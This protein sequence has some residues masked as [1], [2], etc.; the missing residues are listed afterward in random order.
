MGNPQR[1]A[2]GSFNSNRCEDGE[3]EPGFEKIALVWI[4][5][6]RSPRRPAA[7]WLLRDKVAWTVSRHRTR[8][9]G[10]PYWGALRQCLTNREKACSDSVI[11][12]FLESGS[13]PLG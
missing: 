10:G 9:A 11:L 1:Q 8:D 13:T 3:L 2:F 5:I 7:S 4:L 6:V 12:R